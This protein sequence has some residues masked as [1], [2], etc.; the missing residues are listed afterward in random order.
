M[1]SGFV[2]IALLT[3]LPCVSLQAN[4]ITFAQTVFNT[5]FVTSD[6]GLRDVGAGTM[7]VSGITGT[8]TQSLLFWH[9]PTN[10]T[11]PNVNAN[12]NVNGTA[13]TGTNIGFSQ[14][15]FWA[16]ANSQAYRADVTPEVTGNGPVTLSNFQ[17]TTVPNCTSPCAQV[18]GATLFTFYDSGV[19]TNRRDVVLFEGN[20]S[21]FASSFDP[22]GW[23]FT[24]SGINYT[25]GSAFLTL[26]VSDGQDFGP[27]DDGTL[28]VNGTA[29][30][31][32][33]IFQG[34]APKA[35]GAGVSNGSLTDVVTFDI[36][37][38]L[39][40]G[41]NT[42]HITLDPGFSDALSAVVAAVD[43]PAGAAPPNAPE[44]ATYLMVGGA[45]IVAGYR[46]RR[47]RS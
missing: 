27:N 44:P 29:L 19:S 15:N 13:V 21:N 24:L 30:A 28:R 2:Q 26:Y 7:N 6:I 8:V 39:T 20:D 42:L 4:V 5:N 10:S 23:D 40:P 1:R 31:T 22:A 18:N 33:G 47:R 12:V 14:D 37:S 17:K 3:V 9:G 25:S 41:P 36:S 32:G 43:L 45:L 38:F 35:P 11:D 16:S 34:L 46:F